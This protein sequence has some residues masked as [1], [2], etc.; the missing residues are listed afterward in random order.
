MLYGEDGTWLPVLGLLLPLVLWL[1]LPLPDELPLMPGTEL[2][3]ELELEDEDDE[4]E[5]ELPPTAASP[6]GLLFAGVG[7]LFA[8]LVFG[9]FVEPEPGRPG[10]PPGVASGEAVVAVAVGVAAGEVLASVPVDLL[11]SLLVPLP[12]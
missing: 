9:L 5:D 8:G 6:Y 11:L 12:L 7:S 4:E 10:M 2:D 1:L 3:G